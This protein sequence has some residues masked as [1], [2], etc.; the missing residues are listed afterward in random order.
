MSVTATRLGQAL[1]GITPTLV[2]TVPATAMSATIRSLSVAN[3]DVAA[4]RALSVWLVPAGGTPD[5]TNVIAKGLV[6]PFGGAAQD[7]AVHVLMTGGQV[8]GQSD[9]VDGL[10]LTVDGAENT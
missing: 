10:T 6:I 5:D 1:L 4:D 9:A 2:Y 7:D 3:V 8:W